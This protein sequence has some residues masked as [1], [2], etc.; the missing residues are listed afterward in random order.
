MP[1]LFLS[2]TQGFFDN[3]HGSEHWDPWHGCGH[4]KQHILTQDFIQCPQ[5]R[6]QCR[7][8]L[9]RVSPIQVKLSEASLSEMSRLCLRGHS[10]ACQDDHHHR[11]LPASYCPG[12][13]TTVT[14]KAKEYLTISLAI[15]L[16]KSL[17]ISNISSTNSFIWGRRMSTMAHLWGQ[18]YICRGDFCFHH[19]TP[20]DWTG[21]WTWCQGTIPYWA[22]ISGKRAMYYNEDFWQ[23]NFSR[24]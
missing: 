4:S 13:N 21:L 24:Y 14:Q 7:P 23:T 11:K 20:R 10:R 8:Q 1:G 3:S 22:I 19:V 15:I 6:P 16:I 18:R 2:L 12:N 17:Y 5:C 9:G